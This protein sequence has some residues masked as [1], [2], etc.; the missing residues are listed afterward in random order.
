MLNDRER[1][2]VVRRFGLRGQEPETEKIGG[3]S[4]LLGKELG[5]LNG[6]RLKINH[7]QA[8]VLIQPI[9]QVVMDCLEKDGGQV[10]MIILLISW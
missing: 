2:V 1:E 9:R 6:W 7:C 5:K 3:S 10:L 8:L 4:K